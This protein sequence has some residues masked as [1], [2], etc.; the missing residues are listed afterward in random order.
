MPYNG[1]GNFQALPPPQYPAV[2]GDVIRA[3]Y[4]NAVINDLIGGLT[5]AVTRDGQSPPTSNLPMAGK[6]HTGVAD[7]TAPDQYATY[8]QLTNWPF[9]QSGTGAVQRTVTSKL[10]DAAFSVKDFGALGNGVADDTAAINAALAAAGTLVQTTKDGYGAIVTASVYVPS[11]IYICTNDLFV[12]EGVL[13]YGA[14][15][16]TAILKFTVADKGVQMGD[17]TVIYTTA[18]RA[19]VRV[20]DL[21][22]YTS[23]V[24][25]TSIGIKAINCIRQSGIRRCMI[26]GFGFNISLTNSASWAFAVEDCYLHNAVKNHVKA[27]ACNTL[28]FRLLRCETAGEDGIVINGATNSNQPL[29][30]VFDFCV[31][32]GSQFN[33]VKL[34]DAYQAV[35]YDCDMEGNNLTAGGS[36]ADIQAIQGAQLRTCQVLRVHGGFYSAG[37]SPNLTHRIV[38]VRNTAVFHASGVISSGGSNNYDRGFLLASTVQS[39]FIDSCVLNGCTNEVDFTTNA[40]KMFWRDSAGN[41]VLGDSRLAAALLDAQQSRANANLA[42]L[43]NTSSTAGSVTLQLRGGGTAGQTYLM[44][45]LD[46]SGNNISRLNDKGELSVKKLQP[47]SDAGTLQFTNGIFMGTGAPSNANGT[48]GDFY[49]RIDGGGGT[50][51]Y[52]KR[53]GSWVGIV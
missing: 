12:P 26:Y 6:K 39:A 15:R 28:L 46:G 11:G 19:N 13:L 32:Q 42:S 43:Y 5:N 50:S 22:I 45:G 49:F 14:S 41:I 18:F 8:G 23:V 31:V 17:T 25:A 1:A 27:E 35:F 48:N 21:G 20:E 38:D 2:P 51:V 30:L 47:G 3:A 40:T 33:G 34:I 53:A 9:L 16:S 7:A 29:D 37:T 4:F 52:M 10:K 24:S 36:Y 44:Y